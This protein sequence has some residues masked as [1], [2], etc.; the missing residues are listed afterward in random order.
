MSLSSGQNFDNIQ[1]LELTFSS[2]DRAVPPLS[3]W[4]REGATMCV[5]GKQKKP[6]FTGFDIGGGRQ[7]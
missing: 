4:Q 5:K 6:V 3:L 7:V 2:E 1:R